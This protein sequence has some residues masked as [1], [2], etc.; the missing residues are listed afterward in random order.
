MQ[1]AAEYEGYCFINDE[2]MKLPAL[3]S[4]QLARTADFIEGVHHF[5][6]DDVIVMNI[7]YEEADGYFQGQKDAKS[8]VDVIQNRVGLYLQEQM[9]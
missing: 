6:F 3:T 7:I 9:K 4:E 8:V 5:A 2:Y 1:D